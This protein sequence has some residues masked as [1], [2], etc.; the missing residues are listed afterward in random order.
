VGDSP[1]GNT[2]LESTGTLPDYVLGT[3][4]FP[5]DHPYHQVWIEKSRWVKEQTALFMSR[6][7]QKL[8]PESASSDEFLNCQLQTVAGVF[9][10][11]ARAYSCFCPRTEEGTDVFESLLNGGEAFILA[12]A[13]NFRCGSIPRPR[14]LSETRIRLSERKYYWTGQMLKRVREAEEK[15][16]TGG[17]FKP[18]GATEPKD[19][20]PAVNGELDSAADTEAPPELVTQGPAAVGMPE[21]GITREALERGT[22]EAIPG[23]RPRRGRPRSKP[24]QHPEVEPF[25]NR[26]SKAAGRQ[27]TIGQFCVVSGFAD[28]TVFGFWRSGNTE[29]C[30]TV[31]ARRF[32]GTLKL[33]PEQF[34]ARLKEQ[35]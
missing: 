10:I 19:A 14:F 9:D 5:E 22:S 24:N 20:G 25:L 12:L 11:L 30:S 32:E 2:A 16:A 1:E 28:D 6:R 29:R 3:N 31:H 4:P 26:V 18:H 7:L 13:D 34:L 21:Q 33:T 35:G 8:P 15:A 17:E 23:S 27:V